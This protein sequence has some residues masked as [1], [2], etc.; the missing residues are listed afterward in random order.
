MELT[1]V[2]EITVKQQEEALL[3]E[4]AN[5]AGVTGWQDLRWFAIGGENPRSVVIVKRGSKPTQ[6]VCTISR[7]NNPDAWASWQ[8]VLAQ[9]RS[10]RGRTNK[11]RVS[12]ST[13]P[14]GKMQ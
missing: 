2:A 5:T 13:L 1:P 9:L 10:E 12:H 8:P 11:K 14:T 3:T 7:T 6:T 4:I